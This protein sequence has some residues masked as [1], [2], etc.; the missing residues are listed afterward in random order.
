MQAVYDNTT[1]QLV[2][3]GTVVADPL[4]AGLA[5]S[6]LSAQDAAG[7]AE[8][9]RM[10]DPATRTVVATPGWVDPAVIEGNRTTTETNMANDL[11]AMQAT[12]DAT[13]A[14]INSNP[15]PHIKALARA[16]RR[17]IKHGLGDFT[18]PE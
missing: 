9:S 13:N 10:W 18:T 16:M 5:Q 17:V 6:T 3:V 12:I 14:S 1:G 7:L 11:T 2:S 15:A 4:P 8:G